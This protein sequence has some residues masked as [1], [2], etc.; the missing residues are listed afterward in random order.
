M[1]FDNGKFE[2]FPCATIKKAKKLKIKS[3]QPK[4]F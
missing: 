1:T 4:G 3:Y 2:D